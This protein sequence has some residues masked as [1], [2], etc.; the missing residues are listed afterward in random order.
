MTSMI[1]LCEECFP[2]YE[3]HEV[4]TIVPNTPCIVCD[5]FDDRRN[6]GL[7]VN[8]FPR[9]PRAVVKIL[10]AYKICKGN[11]K[12]IC[13]ECGVEFKCYACP[14]TMNYAYTQNLCRSCLREWLYR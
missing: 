13:N 7:I 2:D 8:L 6:K 3:N 9:D 1:V 14:D 5:R 11:S 12:H 10:E 4:N